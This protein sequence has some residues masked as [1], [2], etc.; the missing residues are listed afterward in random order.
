MPNSLA[1]VAMF[2]SVAVAYQSAGQELLEDVE[3]AGV[4]VLP[5]LSKLDK[6]LLYFASS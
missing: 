4:E 3:V 2:L 5:N 1:A 6:K